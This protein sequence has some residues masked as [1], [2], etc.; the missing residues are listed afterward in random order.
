MDCTLQNERMSHGFIV[1]EYEL[2]IQPPFATPEGRKRVDALVARAVQ[3]SKE[4]RTAMGITAPLH[5]IPRPRKIDMNNWAVREYSRLD[6]T[7]QEFLLTA[8]AAT[9]VD[10]LYRQPG[11]TFA[12]GHLPG[13]MLDDF[14]CNSVDCINIQ[15]RAQAM[16]HVMSQDVR[17]EENWISLAC[18][19]AFPTL[20]AAKASGANPHLTLVDFNFNNLW[21]AR[22]LQ[23]QHRDV[24]IDAIAFRDLLTKRDLMD[25]QII[26]Q[27]LAPVIKADLVGHI[28][29]W[30]FRRLKKGHF[31]RAEIMGFMMYLPPEIASRFLYKTSKLVR[32]NG[33]MVFDELSPNHPQRDFYEGCLQWPLT[34]FR[35]IDDTL[36]ILRD[37]KVSIADNTIRIYHYMDDIYPIHVIRRTG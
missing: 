14:F 22:R 24:A 21:H 12:N 35:T 18:G 8:A 20:E 17:S 25:R 28:P 32:E 23:H 10:L 3:L 31:H 4:Y 37:S 15:G 9:T 16:S 36:D 5:D 19:N 6:P 7:F 33:V 13:P 11:S 30:N 26:Q 1:S 2:S 27:M 29:Y 34:R